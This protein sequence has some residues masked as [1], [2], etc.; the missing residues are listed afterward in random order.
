MPNACTYKLIMLPKENY[1]LYAKVY[2]YICVA[3][4][5]PEIGLNLN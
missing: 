4:R 2:K 3:I 5:G 1:Q